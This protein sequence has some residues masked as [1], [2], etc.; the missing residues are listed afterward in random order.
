M[1][2]ATARS[3]PAHARGAGDVLV[4]GLVDIFVF[5]LFAHPGDATLRAVAARLQPS[6][7]RDLIAARPPRPC[8]AL[9]ALDR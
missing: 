5:G 7:A 1:T 9:G 6:R 8:Y 2:A 4:F 3:V